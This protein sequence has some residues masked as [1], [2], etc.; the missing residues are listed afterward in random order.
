MKI[1][2]WRRMP[3]SI[4]DLSLKQMR[5]MLRVLRG[6]GIPG[7]TFEQ[8]TAMKDGCQILVWDEYGALGV[9]TFGH[10]VFGEYKGDAVD[11]NTCHGVERVPWEDLTPDVIALYWMMI[12]EME[13]RTR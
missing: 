2:P 1:Q 12:A 10:D 11:L 8:Q 7:V 4:K 3:T 13:R 5:R 9:M 6:T